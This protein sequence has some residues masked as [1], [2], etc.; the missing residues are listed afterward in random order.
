MKLGSNS[1]AERFPYKSTN[2]EEF[3]SDFK[4]ERIEDRSSKYGSI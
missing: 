3:E 1:R 4:I 2:E